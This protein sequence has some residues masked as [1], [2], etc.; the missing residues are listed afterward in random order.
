MKLRAN[1]SRSIYGNIISGIFLILMGVFVAFPL[2]YSIINAFKPVS[3]LFLFP[4]RFVVYHPTL[5]NFANI[6]RVQSASLVPV[7]RYVFNTVFSSSVCT[8]LY[9]LVSSMAAYPLAKKKFPARNV[10][11][12]TIIFALLFTGDVTSLPRYILMANIGILDTYL[13]LILPAMA[14]TF[15]VFLMMQFMS[16][17][18]DEILE[19]ARIDGAGEKYI[20]FKIVF[21]AVKPATLTLLI[22]T[23]VGAWSNTADNFIYSEQLKML[24][25]MVAQIN[26][27]GIMR[28]GIAAAASVILMIPPIVAFLLCQSSVMET[29]AYSGIKD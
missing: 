10:I 12:Y 21:P 18:P 3:E 5:E 20:F 4:P 2:Y 6:V 1:N 16:T 27:G 23:F 24:P 14:G 28:A 13:A 22:L 19:A 8:G 25:T 7:E 11:Y 29:M 26:A 17:V 15:G 9:I